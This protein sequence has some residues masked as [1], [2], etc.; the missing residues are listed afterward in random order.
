[1]TEQS[2]I[3]DVVDGHPFTGFQLRVLLLCAA[4]IF[5]E[6]FDAQAVGYVAPS[7]SKALHL[8]PGA[9]GP[10]FSAGLFG[11]V[12]G[13]MLI[14]PLADRIGR[15]RVMIFSTAAF[16]LLSLA[17]LLADSVTSLIAIRFLTGLG[18]GGAM[19]NAIALTSEYSPKRKNGFLVM[20]MF[21]GFSFG[22]AGGGIAAAWF[23]RD[24]GWTSIFVVG[25]VLPLLL[26]PVLYFAL[27][28]S[29]R[30]LSLRPETQP[31]A[32][33]LLRRIDP[34][35]GDVARVRPS[36]TEAATSAMSVKQL[37]A[38]RRATGTVLLWVIFAMSLLDINLVSSWLPTALNAGGASLELAALTGS[39]FQLGGII[40]TFAMASV[41][42]RSRPAWLLAGA[43][44]LGAISIGLIAV[45]EVGGTAI[46]VVVALAGFGIVGGQIAANAISAMFYPTPIRSTGVGWALGVGRFGSIVGPLVG[47]FL[48]A[49]DVPPSRLFL[50]SVVPTLIAA[51]A[52]AALAWNYRRIEPET[53][54]ATSTAHS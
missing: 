39:I 15:R 13:A 46:L 49:H 2:P 44:L 17:T 25:G 4:V 41:I 54:I 21:A 19:P 22:S 5:M 14:A 30:F 37:F 51:L 7:I 9:L 18:L 16:G 6:G 43:Y 11:L 29:I 31:E 48:L 53:D 52:S 23:I 32:L 24:F 1:M 10:V 36:Q 50:F 3:S 12:V 20:A 35:L 47:G 33:R 42:D 45:V 38:D 27:P 8:S 34:N 28:E 40:G 26:T